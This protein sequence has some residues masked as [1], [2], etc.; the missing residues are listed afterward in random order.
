MRTERDCSLIAVYKII[1]IVISFIRPLGGNVA[2]V[3]GVRIM[4]RAF[5]RS[6]ST[7]HEEREALSVV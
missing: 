2:K 6:R 7:L 3:M 1:Q 4:G 5:N